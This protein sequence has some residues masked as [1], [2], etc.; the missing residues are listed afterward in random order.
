MNIIAK[1][2]IPFIIALILLGCAK[3]QENYNSPSAPA[4]ELYEKSQAELM[5]GNPE[6]AY[7]DYQKALAIDPRIGN[8]SHFSSILYDWA[9]LQ[10]APEDIPLLKAQKQ[11]LLKPQQLA[12]REQLLL[13]AVDRERGFIYAFGIAAKANGNLSPHQEQLLIPR[14]ALA[15]SQT[16]VARIARWAKDGVKCPFDISSSVIGVEKLK[17]S[18]ISDTIYI[19]KIKA[20]INCLE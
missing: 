2:Q 14:A 11:V 15:D 20:P 4:R 7:H 17:E 1:F 16:W 9:I 10:S 13:S 18:W 19:I 6:K 5:N 3:T 12:L 8:F